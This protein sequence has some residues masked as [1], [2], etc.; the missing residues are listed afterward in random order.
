MANLRRVVLVRPVDRWSTSPFHN[1]TK[2]LMLEG[3][4]RPGHGNLC[5]ISFRAVNQAVRQAQP[6]RYA[7]PV[8][9]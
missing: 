3:N 9:C 1:A 8:C 6:F 2:E 4:D 5:D 7:Y